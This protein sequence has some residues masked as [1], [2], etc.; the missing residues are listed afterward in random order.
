MRKVTAAGIMDAEVIPAIKFFLIKYQSFCYLYFTSSLSSP[1]HPQP[2]WSSSGKRSIPQKSA[3]SRLRMPLSFF[4]GEQTRTA[5]LSPPVIHKCTRW[6]SQR[7]SIWLPGSIAGS[8][9]HLPPVPGKGNFPRPEDCGSDPDPRML[10]AES[11]YTGTSCIRILYIWTG[12]SVKV[13][14]LIPVKD[15][16]FDSLVI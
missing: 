10:S 4:H 5:R 15:Y 1:V 9:V 13:K 14:N 7:Q 12:F 6:F 16:I 11:T 8:Q 2:A 3:W